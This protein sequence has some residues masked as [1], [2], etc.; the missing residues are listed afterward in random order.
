MLVERNIEI[1]KLFSAIEIYR[2]MLFNDERETFFDF[3]LMIQNEY[4]AWVAINAGITKQSEGL[5]IV[6]TNGETLN[7]SVKHKIR[8]NLESFIDAD[9]LATDDLVTGADGR[10]NIVKTIQK[11]SETRFYDLSVVSDSHLYQTSNKL[12]HHNTEICKQLAKTLNIPLIRFDM[13][14]YMEKHSVS[15][16]IGS[17]PGYVGFA[18]GQSGSGMLINEVETNP[19]CVLL[20]DEI[21]KAHY[22]IFNILLQVMDDARLTSGA[23]KTVNF[24]N[25]IL[26]M[27]SNAGASLLEGEPIGFGRTDRNGEDEKILKEIFAP[28]FRNRLDAVIR[29]NRL[30]PTTM[31]KIVDKFIKE[32][33]VLTAQKNV[34]VRV[35]DEAREWLAK[36]GY[37]PKFGARP[38]ARV[39][40]E[41]IKKPLSKEILF[42]K[43]KN[44]G[45]SF[46]TLEADKIQLTAEDLPPVELPLLEFVQT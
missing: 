25:V 4:N 35:S 41:H 46:V 2:K 9:Q 1:G 27:T 20:L 7:C 3:P 19:H 5:E 18:D 26:V 22:D 36:K 32:L 17:P 24:S 38:L 44:G 34:I 29:F 16:L 43:L 10:E 33:N 21:E 14:E 13:S 42:G 11:T 45:I 8:M 39:I 12:V 30:L 31:T 6:F 23:G 40:A 28:E 37:D 15:K